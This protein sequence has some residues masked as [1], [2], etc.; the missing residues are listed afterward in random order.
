MSV[1]DASNYDIFLLLYLKLVYLVNYQEEKVMIGHLH[2]L[3]KQLQEHGLTPEI[4]SMSKE[5]IAT[6]SEYQN[7]ILAHESMSFIQLI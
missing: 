4:L 7:G 3:P 2:L 6:I 5:T 1:L